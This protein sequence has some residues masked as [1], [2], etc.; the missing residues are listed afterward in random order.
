MRFLMRASDGWAH[1]QVGSSDELRE[2]EVQPE[3]DNTD[4]GTDDPCN[5]VSRGGKKT[6]APLAVLEEI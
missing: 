4:D 2:L 5:N 6:D 3:N 1:R